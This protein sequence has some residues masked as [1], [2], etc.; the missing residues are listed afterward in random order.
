MWEFASRLPPSLRFHNGQLKSVLREIVR[1]RVDPNLA[2]RPK[3][4][5][6]VP[7]ERWLADRWSS[8]LDRLTE[9]TELERQGWVKKGSLQKPVAE[10]RARRWVPVQLWYLLVLDHWLERRPS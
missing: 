8:S 5:F 4:G 7:V 6:T 1:R 3:Q 10:A 9:T 2:S